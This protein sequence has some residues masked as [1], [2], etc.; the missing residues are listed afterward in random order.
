[1]MIINKGTERFAAPQG[2]ALDCCQCQSADFCYTSGRMV[3][4]VHS[5]FGI[6]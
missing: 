3:W 6:A 1:M 5:K 2:L 4:I